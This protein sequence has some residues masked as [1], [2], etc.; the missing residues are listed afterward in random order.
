MIFLGTSSG[1][2]ELEIMLDADGDVLVAIADT[3][4]DS[5]ETLRVWIKPDQFPQLIRM[6]KLLQITLD[7][8]EAQR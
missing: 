7:I 2:R 1:S 4:A 6:A 3:D 5:G 8:K